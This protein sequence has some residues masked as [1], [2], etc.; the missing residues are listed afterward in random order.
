MPT[1]LLTRFA[2]RESIGVIMMAVLLFWSAGAVDWWAAW[3]LI[4][5][6]SA[7]IVATGWVIQHRHPGLFAE[8]LG[9]H[10]GAKRWDTIVISL[11]GVLQ[12]CVLVIA[13]LDHRAGWTQAL[14]PAI[15]AMAAVAIAV[16]YGLAVWATANNPFFSLVVR[17]QADRGHHVVSGGP[18]RTIRHPAYAGGLLSQ[19]SIPLL[20]ASWPALLVGA[21]DAGLTVVRTILEDRTLMAELPGYVEY[22]Q[23]VRHRLLPGIW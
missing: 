2:L 9:P 17:I 4:A 16:G 3:T 15:Q 14:P 22:A 20:L 5:V 11:H 1:N 21:A 12:L 7:W 18:Y 13:G 10:P 6:T 23:R 19:V 8:R